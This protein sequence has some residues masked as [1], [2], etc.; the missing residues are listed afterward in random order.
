MKNRLKELRTEKNLTMEDVGKYLNLSKQS[1]NS[2]EK[3][4]RKFDVETLFALANLFDVS[5]YNVMGIDMEAPKYDKIVKEKHLAS[6][7]ENLDQAQLEKELKFIELTK[8]LS[9]E[10]FDKNLEIIK[11]A[12]D[13]TVD[14][15]KEA[16]DFI[17]KIKK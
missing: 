5:V 8:D 15:L 2:W 1:V 11:A 3:Y 12:K 16:I 17:K 10:D 9:E 14:E 4:H 13:V 6:I 7:L